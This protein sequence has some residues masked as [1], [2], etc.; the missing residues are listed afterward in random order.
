MHRRGKAIRD[1][2]TASHVRAAA[3][4]SDNSELIRFRKPE[5]A[6]VRAAGS[7]EPSKRWQCL[8]DG[9][10]HYMFCSMLISTLQYRAIHPSP[11]LLRLQSTPKKGLVQ[12]LFSSPPAAF[13]VS[14]LAFSAG[15]R[16]KSSSFWNPTSS[17][18][19]SAPFMLATRVWKAA[20]LSLIFLN[21]SSLGSC[22]HRRH[23]RSIYHGTTSQQL[24]LHHLACAR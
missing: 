5:S 21:F 17:R 4:R 2:L 24:R 22:V 11:S 16:R 19:L 3:C 7:S 9:M 14:A 6:E 8:Q 13:N 18:N 20:L 12:A 10:L 1:L 23:E 15:M